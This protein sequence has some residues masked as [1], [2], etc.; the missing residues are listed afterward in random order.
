MKIL[1]LNYAGYN[2]IKFIYLFIFI[3]IFVIGSSPMPE[4]STLQTILGDVD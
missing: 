2:L 4:D 1:F 3:F